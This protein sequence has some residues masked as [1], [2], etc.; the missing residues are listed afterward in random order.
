[1]NNQ[2]TFF[3]VL[4][5]EEL[6]YPSFNNMNL[7]QIIKNIG[8]KTGHFFVPTETVS[9]NETEMGYLDEADY[10]EI[11]DNDILYTLS[12]NVYEYDTLVACVEKLFRQE[13]TVI[14]CEVC[15]NLEDLIT[16]LHDDAELE[17]ETY[18]ESEEDIDLEDIDL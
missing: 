10:I 18:I 16:V 6:K 1:M 9:C 8:E 13:H 3:D 5:Q 7:E 12:F 11:R 17:V 15:L 2:L 4:P 14:Y